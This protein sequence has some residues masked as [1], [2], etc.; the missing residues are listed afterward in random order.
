MTG[1][2]AFGLPFSEGVY[3]PAA[4]DSLPPQSTYL[5]N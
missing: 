4:A 5:L 3:H 1:I 2:T